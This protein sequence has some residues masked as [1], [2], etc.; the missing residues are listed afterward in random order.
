MGLGKTFVGSEKLISLKKNINL[1]VCQKSLIST[2][3]KHFKDNYMIETYNLTD[4]NNLTQFMML[5]EQKNTCQFIGIINYDLLFRRK[6]LLKLTDFTLMLDESSVI[7][8]ETSK[9]SKFIFKMKPSRVILLSGTPTS[10]KYENLYSQLKLLGWDIDKKLY[11]KQ[12]ID[13]EWLEVGE[14]KVP[15]VVGYKNVE[16]LKSKLKQHGAIFMKTEDVLSLPEQVHNLV[17]VKSTKEY[18]YYIQH[19]ILKSDDLE[20][21]GDTTL[22]KRLYARMLASCYNENKIDALKDLI[23]STEDR[24]IIF[25]NFN[26]ELEKLKSITDR[27]ISVVNGE[28]KDLTNY[29]EHENSITF[30]QYQAGSMGL[31]LQKSNK[32]IYFSLPER[33]ELFEQSKK[34]THRIGQNRTCFYYYLITENSIDEDIYELLEMRK[35]YTDELFRKKYGG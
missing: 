27:P 26:K 13:V 1:I 17:K 3:L 28:I 20:L 4:K 10:G 9:R 2:W 32:I 24:L 16:R 5:C 34:R 7:Q 35:D 21:V 30:I 25:Y 22:T 18:N 23:D 6:E 33:S 31:N 15:K 12:Y 19:S 29:E 14:F 8:N 11:W